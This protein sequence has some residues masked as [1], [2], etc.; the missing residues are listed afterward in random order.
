MFST[1]SS[2]QTAT[3]LILRTRPLTDT[4]LI[5]HWLAP[6]L[7]RIATVALGARRPRSPLRGKLDLFYLAEFSFQR[8]RRSDLHTLR[9]V[10]LR[11]PHASLRRDLAGLRQATYCVMLLERATETETPLPGCYQL[12]TAFL[13]YLDRH[14]PCPGLVLGFEMQMLADLGLAPDLSH[15]GL[16]ATACAALA[17][18]RDGSLEA[19]LPLTL[20]ASALAEVAGFLARALVANFDRLPPNRAVALAASPSSLTAAAP[21]SVG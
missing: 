12:L 21:P 14:E 19:V 6:D 9:E 4:S 15:S 13:D 1:G 7:G 5:V 10:V 16:S 18:L 11:N 20:N 8:S 3:G 17:R 2:S